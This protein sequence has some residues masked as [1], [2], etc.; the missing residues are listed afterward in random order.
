MFRLS[1][2]LTCSL[3]YKIT[4]L[5]PSLSESHCFELASTR[6]ASSELATRAAVA[7]GCL[8][9]VLGSS[10]TA[11]GIAT[12]SLGGEAESLAQLPIIRTVDFVVAAEPTIA[13][14]R[15]VAASTRQSVAIAT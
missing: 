6:A 14:I 11:A 7:R 3:A 2:K 8:G 12:G 9:S 4:Y 10:Q 5:T 13:G 15:T 1:M